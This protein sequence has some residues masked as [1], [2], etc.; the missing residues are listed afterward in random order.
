MPKLTKT[1]ITPVNFLTNEE[2][3]VVFLKYEERCATV[4]QIQAGSR[5][6]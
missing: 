2:L 1:L 6:A 5:A 4:I 3:R